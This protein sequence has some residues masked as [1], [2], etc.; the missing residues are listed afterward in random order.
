MEQ[1]VESNSFEKFKAMHHFPYF[2]DI[3][4]RFFKKD[5]LENPVNLDMGI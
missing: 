5:F 2:A 1:S 3:S 4:G